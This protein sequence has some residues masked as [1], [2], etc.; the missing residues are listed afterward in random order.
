MSMRTRWKPPA[1]HFVTAWRPSM[2]VCQRTLS[3]FIKAS[4]SLRFMMLSS[5]INTFMG[6]TPPL[7]KPTGRDGCSPFFRDFLALGFGSGGEL[8]LCTSCDGGVGRLGT[9]VGSAAKLSGALLCAR[10][11]PARSDC[12]PRL[13]VVGDEVWVLLVLGRAC[14]RRAAPGEGRLAFWP[15]AIIE[16]EPGW[17]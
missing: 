15:P 6:G 16:I 5:T 12:A 14:G 4:S 7:S 10:P 11:R 13:T 9:A 1:R 8:I 2:A 3:R 17:W